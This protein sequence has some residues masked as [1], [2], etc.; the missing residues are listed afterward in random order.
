VR[1]GA[2]SEEAGAAETSCG[3]P[4]LGGGAALPK[5]ERGLRKPA[6]AHLGSAGGSAGLA[7]L[8]ATRRSHLAPRSAPHASARRSCA[9]DPN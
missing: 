5:K 8:A 1:Q 7:V 3:S 9:P 6:A 4:G 2:Q